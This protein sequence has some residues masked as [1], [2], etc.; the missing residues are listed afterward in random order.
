MFGF[1]IF[2]HKL[3][4][5]ITLDV[6]YKDKFEQFSLIELIDKSVH[7]KDKVKLLDELRDYCDSLEKELEEDAFLESVEV[8]Y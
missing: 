3:N 2:Y 5:E 4:K 1:D 7:N 8:N 6:T